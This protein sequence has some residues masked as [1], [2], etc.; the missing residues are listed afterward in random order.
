MKFQDSGELSDSKW[1]EFS[2]SIPHLKYFTVCHWE[3]LEFFNI[4]GHY[5]WNY[6]SITSNDIKNMT[7]MQMWYK[8]DIRSAGR[9]IKMGIKISDQV[10][11]VNMKPFHHRSW[12][13]FCW[14]YSSYTGKNML[15]MNG[16]LQGDVIFA[17]GGEIAGD[18]EV[19]D[20]SFSI[21]QEPD[22]LRGGYDKTQAYRGS[23]SELN[24]WDY[25][26]TKD[27]ISILA[28]CKDDA[29]GNIISWAVENFKLYNVSTNTIE[30][31][32]SLFCTPEE[33]VV[34]FPE[35]MFR[36]DAVKL[37]QVHGGYLYTPRSSEENTAIKEQLAPFRSQCFDSS[38]GS[39]AWLGASVNNSQFFRFDEKQNIVR[40]NFSNLSRD[41]YSP[42][43]SCVSVEEH[44]FWEAHTS[45]P[46]IQLCAV[47]G[48]LGTPV[49][50]LKGNKK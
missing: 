16:E 48:F 31:T 44:G 27:N 35:K 3:K 17:V 30:S 39:V 4:Q 49:L 33:K 2:G 18:A 28:S 20:S 7:C 46:T 9:N 45:C 37:C 5:I 10:G 15:F 29:T 8:R 25:I 47:C 26:L 23:I 21:A 40:S 36:T 11:Y 24:M 22:E 6:C 1:A 38:S 13:Y 34:V 12:N 32:D 43:M 41:L 19:Q 42:K 50:T 14:S